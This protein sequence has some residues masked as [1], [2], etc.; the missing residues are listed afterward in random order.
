MKRMTV[1]LL[2]FLFL[3]MSGLSLARNV[4]MDLRLDQQQ[5]NVGGNVSVKVNIDQV[6]DLKGINILISFDNLKLRYKSISKEAIIN[7]FVEDILPKVEI[8]NTTGKMEYL[9]VRGSRGSGVDFSG[10]SILSINFTAIAPGEASVNLNPNDVPLGD[11]IANAIPTNIDEKPKTVR[12][13]ELYKIRVFNYPNPA[14]DKQGNT[15]IRCEAFAHL[16]D[17][18]TRIYDISGEPVKIIDFNEFKQVKPLTFDYT[19]DCTNQAG[20]D[21]ANGTYILWVKASF[22]GS[23]AQYETWKIAILR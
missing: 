9:A 12:I 16:K 4:S 22:D 10:G 11:S 19:W 18:E 14:P 17:L 3:S 13:G 5:V 8:S 15:I 6:S 20:R 23:E 2:V 21:V 1:A 7:D